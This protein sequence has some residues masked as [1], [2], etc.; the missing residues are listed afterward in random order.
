MGLDDRVHR[1]ALVLLPATLLFS[2]P[3]LAQSDL[4]AAPVVATAGNEVSP[5][6]GINHPPQRTII[7]SPKTLYDDDEYRA[8]DGSNNNK[9]QPGMGTP[10]TRLYRL[11]SP[12]YADGFSA[13]AGAQRPGARVISNKIFHQAESRPNNLDAS[14]FLW[15]WGQFLDHDIDLTDG[16]DPA[17]HANIPVPTGDPYFDPASSGKA[18]IP[19][20]RS[21]YD[22]NSSTDAPRQQLNEITAW[23]DASNVYGTDPLRTDAL[24]THAGDGKLKT[25]AGNLLPFNTYGLPNAGGAS[26]GLFLAGD[27]RANE[28]TGLTALHTLFV[29]EHNRLAE[30]IAEQSPDLNG[31]E[32]FL[33][34]RKLVGAEMQMITYREYLPALLGPGALSPYRGYDSTRD[35]SIANVFSAAAYRYGHSALNGTLLRMDKQGQEIQ[36]GHLALRD[37][38][39]NPSRIIDEGGIDPVLRGLAMQRSQT[40]DTKIVD[41]VRNF[42][43]GPPGAGG[44]DLAA[45]NIQRGR[46]HGLPSYN[47]V[48]KALGFAGAENFTDVSSDPDTVARLASAY[49]SVDDIDLWVG[50]LAEDPVP[51]S[52]LG[53]TFHRIIKQQFEAL[54]DGDRYWYSINL[55]GKE[56]GLIGS[57]RLS[58]IIRLNTGIGD[59][60]RKNVFRVP[61]K[62]AKTGRK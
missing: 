2:V 37:A 57:L 19:F 38:F 9:Q 28:Q 53:P 34:A 29:R 48:R 35:A 56:R 6:R 31:D 33:Q 12:D 25:S 8:I 40:I 55:S 58:D 60:L 51:R 43:F 24:R 50:G 44:F 42:L 52:H 49:T 46:D 39:F 20:N 61:V 5:A 14:D 59:E 32:I 47:H 36:F 30:L 45:L 1:A 23:I 3:A 21:L 41:D 10:H 62:D 22:K 11:M 27:V 4:P 7:R 18:E 15:Q 26:P 17:E 54:R 16:T 13:L